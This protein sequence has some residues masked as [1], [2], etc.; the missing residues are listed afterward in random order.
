MLLDNETS[1]G[2][3]Y[4]NLILKCNKE[5]NR[6][7]RE[8]R[9]YKSILVLVITGGIFTQTSF[10]LVINAGRDFYQISS[11]YSSTIEFQSD[12]W[13]S[14]KG[15]IL[16]GGNPIAPETLYGTSIVIERKENANLLSGQSNIAQIDIE[17]KSFSLKSVNP[18]DGYDIFI[19]LNS[20]IPSTG[21]MDIDYFGWMADRGNWGSYYFDVALHADAYIAPAGLGQSYADYYTSFDTSINSILDASWFD[22]RTNQL[23]STGSDFFSFGGSYFFPSMSYGGGDADLYIYT[24]N[25]TVPE[26]TS[27]IIM[28]LGAVFLLRF[29]KAVK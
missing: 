17:V 18:I 19:T 12:P 16:F 23:P 2:L 20:E 10:G 9:I 14:V 24:I 1:V 29:R 28:S 15:P 4:Y 25:T 21:T 7:R 6:R 8:I 5:Y 13:L 27:F 3:Q 22:L 26:P 11:E